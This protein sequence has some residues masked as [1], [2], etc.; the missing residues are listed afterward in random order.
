M[1]LTVYKTGGVASPFGF[2]YFFVIFEA[3]RALGKTPEASS[4]GLRRHDPSA[5]D[6]TDR[7]APVRTCPP[8]EV[9]G[10]TIGVI[11]IDRRTTG[12]I[13]NEEF[14]MFQVF[15]NQSAITLH[16]VEPDAPGCVP[17]SSLLTNANLTQLLAPALRGLFCIFSA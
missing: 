8:L 14:R 13:Q 15:A 5:R 6:A 9:R 4:S 17:S 3:A 2:L 12:G 10:T 11:G 1:S 7:S 16:G